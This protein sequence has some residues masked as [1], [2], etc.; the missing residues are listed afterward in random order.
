MENSIATVNSGEDGVVVEKVDL[1]ETE[2]S[3]SSFK[4]L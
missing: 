4:S 3:L 1:E 2:I